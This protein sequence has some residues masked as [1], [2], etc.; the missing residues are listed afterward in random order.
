M[1]YFE[2][3][4]PKII[5]NR[6]FLLAL[7]IWSINLENS[8]VATGLEKVNFHSNPQKGQYQRMFKLSH[9]CTHFTCQQGNA[10]NPSSQVSTIGELRTPR[11]TSW[12]QKWQRNRRSNCQHPLDQ[13]RSKRFQKNIYF[14]FINYAKAFVWITTNCGKFFKRWEYQTTLLVS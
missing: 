1:D 8:A 2:F 3:I 7:F 6:I 10:Q 9:N 12:I 13:R 11:C 5:V 4:T 14:C